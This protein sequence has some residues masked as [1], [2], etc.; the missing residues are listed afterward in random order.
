MKYAVMF[1]LKCKKKVDLDNLFTK[2]EDRLQG[3]KRWENSLNRNF[4]AKGED[5]KGRPQD[6]GCQRFHSELDARDV[7]EHIKGLADKIPWISGTVHIHRCD[8][9]Q[10]QRSGCEVIEE[11]SK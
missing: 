11:F 3:K 10:E 6:T 1:N 2:I 8:H 5:E 4:H 9:D 7:F